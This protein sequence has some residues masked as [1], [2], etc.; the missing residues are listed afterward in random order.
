MNKNFK[1]LTIDNK[2][3]DELRFLSD[4]TGRPKVEIIR[5]IVENLF[6]IGATF[7][8]FNYNLYPDGKSGLMIQFFGKRAL[9]SGELNDSETAIQIKEIEG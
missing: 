3:N 9:I 4:S 8:T 6:Y 5:E 7:S 1:T 2:L